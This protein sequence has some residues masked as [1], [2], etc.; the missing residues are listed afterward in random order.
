M[1]RDE[2]KRLGFSKECYECP[3][4]RKESSYIFSYFA[5]FVESDAIR[6]QGDQ[7]AVVQAHATRIGR[8]LNK[9]NRRTFILFL[10]KNI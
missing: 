7:D 3:K 6:Q 5:L 1:L 4:V 10:S 9:H 8:V 2:L